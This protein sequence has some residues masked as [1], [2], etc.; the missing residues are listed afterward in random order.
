MCTNE[1]E[2]QRLELHIGA[3]EKPPMGEACNGCGVCCAAEPCPLSRLLLRRQ[4]GACRA[5]RW[6][7][8]HGRY[9]CGLILQP[10][11]YPGWLPAPLARLAARC[12]RRW[13]A[14]GSRCDS[15]VEVVE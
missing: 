13:I 5:L 3:P 4:Q 10:A 12:V 8:E 9:R 14:A 11:G 6:Q 2:I 1:N 15:G 7:P